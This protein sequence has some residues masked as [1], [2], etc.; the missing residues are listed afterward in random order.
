MSNDIF[1]ENINVGCDLNKFWGL[2][3]NFDRIF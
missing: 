3:R 1:D 2:F